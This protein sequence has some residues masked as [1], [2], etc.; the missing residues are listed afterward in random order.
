MAFYKKT[1]DTSI[2][3]AQVSIKSP[4]YELLSDNRE[5][6]NYPIDGWYWFDTED[7]AYE[8]FQVEKPIMNPFI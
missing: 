7:E 4:D 1:S 6:Y 8:F 5:T 3:D 2:M